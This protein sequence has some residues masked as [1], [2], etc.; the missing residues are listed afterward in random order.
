VGASFPAATHPVW[1]L[2]ACCG[3]AIVTAGL[4][5][6]TPWARRTASAAL[7]HATTEPAAAG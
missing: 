1:W 3:V 2:M 6:T 5:T 4:V 7:D